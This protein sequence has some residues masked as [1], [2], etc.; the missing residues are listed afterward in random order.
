MTNSSYNNVIDTLHWLRSNNFV[1]VPLKYSSKH[2]LH[3][4]TFQSNYNPS[5]SLWHEQQLNIGVLTGPKRNGPLD[6]DLDCPE[7]IALAPYFL[8]DT[9]AMF[10][11]ASKPA[12]HYLYKTDFPSPDFQTAIYRDPSEK[13]TLQ[14]SSI[15]F[16]MRGNNSQTM[17]PGSIH[18]S[19]EQVQW[20]LSQHTIATIEYAPLLKASKLLAAACLAARYMWLDGYRHETT[21]QLAGIFT[22]LERPI[23][24]C[25][26]FIRALIA[27]SGTD[28]PA[29]FATIKTTYNR[30]S[31]DRAKKA[32]FSL[33]KRFG[34]TNPHMVKLFLEL[35]GL[36]DNIWLEEL[37]EKYACVLLADRYRVAILAPRAGGEV[38]FISTEDF[39][40]Y[41]E[42]EY[43]PFK[44]WSKTENAFVTVQKPKADAWLVNPN[45]LKF[46]RVEF[47]PGS[48][49]ANTETLNKFTGWPLAPINNPS[50]CAAFI[51]YTKHLAENN[52]DHIKWILT[53]FA[54]ILKTPLDKQRSA[55][56]IIGPQNIGKSVY[57][58]YFG[59]ILGRYHLSI[60]DALKIH[61]RFNAHLE[62][63]LLLHSDEAIYGQDKKHRSI[64][65]DLISSKSLAFEA[66]YQGVWTAP[67]YLRLVYTSND[68]Y[69]APVELGDTRH[70]IF[71]M[72]NNVPP[73][74][75]VQA[76]Y[77]EGV[78]N[79]P[80]CLMQY[81]LDYDYNPSVLQNS[82]KSKVKA[83]AVVN[84]LDAAD[85]YWF[86]KL[87]EGELLPPILRWA[88]DDVIYTWPNEVSRLALYAE[89][90]Q[91]TKNVQRAAPLS[92][93][94]FF[95]KLG[96]W[97]NTSPTFK[98]KKYI[99]PHENDLSKPQWVREMYSGLHQT[100]LAFP[101]L[102]ICRAAFEK[103][104]GQN[105]EW[106]KI[107]PDCEI[108]QTSATIEAP[109]Y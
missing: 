41:L 5:D 15:L 47:I 59:K 73:H 61:G 68:D 98:V 38:R 23:E 21:M 7:A 96:I 82:L 81:L 53:F 62:Q 29:H 34:P 94:A 12:S 101:E 16:E 33:R 56:V 48:Q 24:D 25:E 43:A 88:Q 74:D 106:Q 65:K 66:K 10:G 72:K 76:L 55:L 63:C 103:Y 109:S 80:A 93:F 99:N 42:G 89:Y 39:K 79:G 91:Y 92:S 13:N 87:T 35:L 1:P 58:T 97:T 100:L 22:Q 83:I 69:A 70:S 85:I 108:E 95:R 49:P 45:R 57:V 18:D 90:L 8:P 86:N 50:G 30:A 20:L 52:P 102:D 6:I 19:G 4:E 67:S 71:S 78:A 84:S 32:S 14:G 37:N 64:I 51:E 104:S 28:D 75:L 17:M 40:K 9:G 46:E 31:N 77:D 107:V 27:Y 11:R 44:K 2:V 3:K 26:H 105:Y 54:H 36:E 60:A